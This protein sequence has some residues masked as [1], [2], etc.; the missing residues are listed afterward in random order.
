MIRLVAQQGTEDMVENPHRHFVIQRSRQ[1]N[2]LSEIPEGRRA[3]HFLLHYLDPA[4]RSARV[5]SRLRFGDEDI[6]KL[7]DETRKRL[8]N[9]RDP[10]GDLHSS[11]EESTRSAAPQ[12]RGDNRSPQSAV[13]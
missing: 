13:G 12:Y 8:T 11:I 1:I 4:V 3:E 6:K 9:L 10:L 7:V 2:T 5:A